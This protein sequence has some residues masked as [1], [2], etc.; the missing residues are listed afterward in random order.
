MQWYWTFNLSFMILINNVTLFFAVLC[1]SKV[2][3]TQFLQFLA[4]PYF[5]CTGHT[6]N[7]C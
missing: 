2:A 3:F 6:T 7:S 5:M 1:R 4:H